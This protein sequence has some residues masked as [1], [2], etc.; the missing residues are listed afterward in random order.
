MTNDVYCRVMAG[1]HD[2]VRVYNHG[3]AGRIL[4]GQTTHRLDGLITRNLWTAVARS[5]LDVCDAV[6]VYLSGHRAGHQ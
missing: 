5:T 3:T 4:S 6:H 1:A 2:D